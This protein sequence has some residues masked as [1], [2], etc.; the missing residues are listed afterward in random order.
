M[1]DDVARMGPEFEVDPVDE[2]VYDGDM[3]YFT[4]DRLEHS[5]QFE[6]EQAEAR[7]T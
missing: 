7:E 4:L 5:A 3:G 2:Y 6:V 1:Q